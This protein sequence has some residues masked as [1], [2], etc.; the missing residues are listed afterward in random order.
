M[1]HNS[2]SAPSTCR[3]NAPNLAVRQALRRNSRP[4]KQED[5]C[6]QCA[7]SVPPKLREQGR[8]A[9]SESRRTC[10]RIVLF[11]LPQ[12]ARGRP[13][14]ATWSSL[15]AQFRQL[16]RPKPTEYPIATM[17]RQKQCDLA[18]RGEL[19]SP[20]FSLRDEREIIFVQ[21]SGRYTEKERLNRQFPRKRLLLGPYKEHCRSTTKFSLVFAPR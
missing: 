14:P 5:N 13:L 9:P 4:P 1:P 17:I 8:S 16:S 7:Q 21:P 11:L 18:A 19:Q 12:W 2:N 15:D 10:G 20:Q 6:E 3:T